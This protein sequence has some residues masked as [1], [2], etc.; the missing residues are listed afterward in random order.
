MARGSRL[1]KWA[2]ETMDERRKEKKGRP[3]AWV[4][5]LAAIVLLILAL[6]AWN[7]RE[8]RDAEDAARG[9]AAAVV[10]DEARVALST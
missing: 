2:P 8:T 4:V 10:I 7:R 6:L 5:T 9:P 3:I 1:I